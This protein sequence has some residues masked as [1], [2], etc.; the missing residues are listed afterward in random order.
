MKHETMKCH[1]NG[2]ALIK[3]MKK[4]GG[5]T[6]RSNVEIAE[7][8]GITP[9]AF[10]E[11]REHLHTCTLMDGLIVSSRQMH[12]PLVLID[13]NTTTGSLVELV[14]A[15]LRPVRTAH[16]RNQRKADTALERMISV[17]QACADEASAR[18]NLNVHRILTLGISDL[19]SPEHR[20]N[21]STELLM[22][23]AGITLLV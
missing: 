14:A 3:Y 21:R 20:L 17:W 9:D 12:K 2:E 16:D 4:R 23:Q 22:E 15:R 7:D 1:V 13:P 19:K 5:K 6:D 10:Y 11:A 18:G 8:L